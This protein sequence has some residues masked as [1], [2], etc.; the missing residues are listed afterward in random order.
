MLENHPKDSI[1]FLDIETVPQYQNWTDVPENFQRLWKKK[2]TSFKD[3]D[4]A[5]DNH[6]GKAGIYA[7]FGKII[8]I[9]VGMFLSKEEKAVFRMKSYASSDEKKLL[10]EFAT[11]LRKFSGESNK[12]LCAHNGKDFD[13]PYIA[14]R[15][16]IHGLK[17]PAMLDNA[18]KKPW[19]IKLL[20]TMELWKFGDYK[21]FTS[22]DL[23]TQLFK[24]PT[25]KDDIDGSQVAKV[26]YEDDDLARI[27]SYCEKDVV[28]I[29]QLFLRWKAEPLIDDDQIVVV[30]TDAKN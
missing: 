27:V 20:D 2:A 5:E 1:L 28:A 25:P 16:L 23:L 14:R 9:T 26:F 15:L 4:E 13:F 18:G 22:L 7:E 24:I 10:I 30:D 17:I 8:C 29:A 21:H 3:T 12:T 11:M 19:E 6:Y